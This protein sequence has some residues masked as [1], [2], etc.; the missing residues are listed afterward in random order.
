MQINK[1]YTYKVDQLTR[2]RLAEEDV[3]KEQEKLYQ[4]ITTKYSDRIGKV[5]F[6]LC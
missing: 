3:K 6:Y 5:L 4:D 2:E 1:E